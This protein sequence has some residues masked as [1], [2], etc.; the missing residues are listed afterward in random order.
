MKENITI[1]GFLIT[2]GIIIVVV[3][4]AVNF[5]IKQREDAQESQVLM[6][7]KDSV[8]AYYKGVT[9]SL[10]KRG[11]SDTTK[12]ERI[13]YPVYI[14]RPQGIKFGSDSTHYKIKNEHGS[15]DVTTFPATDSIRLEI[16]PVVIVKYIE[17]VDTLQ[18]T[19]IDSVYVQR[20]DTLK[21]TTKADRPFYDHWEFGAVGATIVGII[22][23]ILIGK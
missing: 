4:F 18:L 11:R 20:V 10:L 19:R 2:L 17:R 7:G 5:S 14:E 13:P 21:I 1:K 9:D 16:E 3:L 23:A 12:I 6:K 8:I 22:T 15:V